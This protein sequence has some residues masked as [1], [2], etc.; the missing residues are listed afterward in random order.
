MGCRYVID[1]SYVGSR[2]GA[3][4]GVLGK[5]SYGKVY[6]VKDVSDGALC[7]L[8]TSMGSVCDQFLITPPESDIH[9]RLHHPHL[10]PGKD[11]F[12]PADVDTCGVP[13]AGVQQGII[14]PLMDHNL[15]AIVDDDKANPKYPTFN[16][17]RAAWQLACALE[18]LYGAGYTHFD[19]K[20]D[21]IL[22]KGNDV[23]LADFGLSY[24]T[25]MPVL[26]RM[27][28]TLTYRAPFLQWKALPIDP[29]LYMAIDVYAL[30]LV[31]M[32]MTSGFVTPPWPSSFSEDLEDRYVGVLAGDARKNVDAMIK[33]VQDNKDYPGFLGMRQKRWR[34]PLSSLET[35]VSFFQLIKAMLTRR[36]LT[37]TQVRLWL[38]EL[39]PLPNAP[40]LTLDPPLPMNQAYRVVGKS[41]LDQMLTPTNDREAIHTLFL[42]MTVMT[43]ATPD[44]PHI[45]LPNGQ[46]TWVIPYLFACIQVVSEFYNASGIIRPPRYKRA[47]SQAYVYNYKGPLTNIRVAV[48]AALKMIVTSPVLRGRFNMRLPGEPDGYVPSSAAM[49]VD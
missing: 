27:V 1:T 38:E 10:L 22:V 35:I 39:A 30:G 2:E 26:N 13:L 48:C 36:D 49:Q 33:F 42:F 11:V 28:A 14:L 16:A 6:L 47:D 37:A 25:A 41:L 15:I 21:N 34:L 32:E 5:G 4:P 23:F 44:S 46:V 9:M 8:K 29:S 43:L 45:G 31:F 3:E 19:I 12:V 18:A 17:H 24:S 20:P 40:S 7:A